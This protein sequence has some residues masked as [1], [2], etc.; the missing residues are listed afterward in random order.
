MS[1]LPQKLGTMTEAEYLEFERRSDMK[2]EYAS[3]D[4][5]AMTGASWNHN[6]ICQNTATSLGSQ[7]ADRDCTVVSS[8]MRVQIAAARAYR[9]P[10]VI[11]VC[12][13]PQFM[14]DRM[15][16]IRNPVILIEVLSPSTALVDRNEKLR[17]YRQLSSLQEYLL[18][19]QNEPRIERFLRQ[20]ADNWLYTE[21]VGL[22]ESIS[23]P[24]VTCTLALSEVYK[25]VAFE[26]TD[27]ENA[28]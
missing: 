12:G 27:E 16:T 11:V 26:S 23:L 24:S 10:D 6:V 4:V 8:D 9:Y 21:V 1:A 17:E 5:L 25:K 28:L 7:L 2:H 19:S 3:G 13:Q 20:D 14:D 22:D 18:I 15:D